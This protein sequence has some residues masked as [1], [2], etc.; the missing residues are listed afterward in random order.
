MSPKPSQRDTLPSSSTQT[1]KA[2]CS[3]LYFG[4]L[5]GLLS[6]HTR[7]PS[8]PCL[9]R[10]QYGGYPRRLSR[11]ATIKACGRPSPTTKKIDVD[12]RRDPRVEGDDD[13]WEIRRVLRISVEPWT[14]QNLT[15]GASVMVNDVCL[16]SLP[17]SFLTTLLDDTAS[18]NDRCRHSGKG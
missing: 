16:S 17:F 1:S 10:N 9:A 8:H 3:T 7:Q 13:G 5:H 6:F 12:V 15:Y 4:Q 18:V 2:R 11:R 14:W